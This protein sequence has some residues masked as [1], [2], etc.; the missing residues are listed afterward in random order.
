VANVAALNPSIFEIFAGLKLHAIGQ[1]A[2]EDLDLGIDVS[3][4]QQ[5]N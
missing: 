4:L 1:S 5:P 3:C 2:L